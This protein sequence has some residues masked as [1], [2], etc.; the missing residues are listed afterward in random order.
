MLNCFTLATDLSF[1]NEYTEIIET[2]FLV[3]YT[4]EMVLK[5]I[6][7]GFFMRQHS[8]LREAWNF[9]DFV[10][11]ILGWVLFIGYYENKD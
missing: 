6:A 3:I 10:V 8:Y 5:I 7:L 1:F 2:A 11:V 4:A 9:L